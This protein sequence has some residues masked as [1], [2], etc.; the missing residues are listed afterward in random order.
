MPGVRQYPE[1]TQAFILEQRVTT[2][3]GIIRERFLEGSDQITAGNST[4][5]ITHKLE[6][7]PSSVFLTPRSNDR[8]WLTAIGATTFT[9]NRSGTS[10]ILG[11][12]W[13]TI[14]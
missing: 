4:E 7:V 3:E 6:V 10:G 14:P 9:V 8:V 11:F 5:V 12:Y 13:L 1:E 2:L